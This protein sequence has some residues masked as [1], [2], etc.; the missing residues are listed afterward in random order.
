MSTITAIV[1]NDAGINLRKSHMI[2][3][4]CSRITPNGYDLRNIKLTGDGKTTCPISK[5]GIV[6]MKW[7]YG[8]EITITIIEEF[9]NETH[10]LEKLKET[11]ELPK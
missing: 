10:L 4:D 3:Q 6:A 2:V 7:K 1:G 9:D 8:T 11:I 5:K